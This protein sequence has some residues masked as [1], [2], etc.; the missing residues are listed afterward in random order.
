[1]RNKEQIKWWAVVIWL[2]VLQVASMVLASD[3]LLV[4]PIKVIAR[5]SELIVTS[6]FWLAILFSF[7]RIVGGFVAA[8]GLGILFAGLSKRFLRFRQLIT[9]LIALIKSVPVAS[10]IILALIWFSSK[11]LSV[12]I[13]FMIVFPVVY[14]NVLG[15]IEEVDTKLIEMAKV[16]RLSNVR[17]LRY[18]YFPQV[19]PSIRTAC[20]LGL[21][22]CWKAGIAA[23][24]IGMPLGS[25]G[26][27]L[28]QAKI[29]LNTPDLFA[30]TLVIV[31]ISVVF[32]KV[33]LL[34]LSMLKNR[35]ER[36]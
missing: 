10:F 18:I 20:S 14:T 22:M 30:W 28:Q 9:P 8:L 27:R 24:V 2:L 17:K 36:I 35:L 29:F 7:L 3:I 6:K 5:L 16:Y 12:L 4:S 33:F 23:E 1:M 31:V 15:G 32:E 13:S 34:L 19:F 11:N 26:E 25:V 21:G